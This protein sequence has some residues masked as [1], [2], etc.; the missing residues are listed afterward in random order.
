MNLWVQVTTIDPIQLWK[1]PLEKVT[2]AFAAQYSTTV[3]STL[4]PEISFIVGTLDCKIWLALDSP[5]APLTETKVIACF[6]C[7]IDE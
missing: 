3:D 4:H 7:F 2:E 5:Q 6:V 1:G